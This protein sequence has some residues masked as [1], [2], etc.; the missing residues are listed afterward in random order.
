MSLDNVFSIFIGIMVGLTIGIFIGHYSVKDE[1]GKEICSEESSTH[2]FEKEQTIE[3]NSIGKEIL[4][5]EILKMNIQ[6]PQIVLAQAILESG[7]FES[8]VFQKFN[9]MFGMKIPRQRS[10]TC[11][12]REESGYAEY[13]DWQSS[14]VDYAIWQSCFARNLSE[15]EYFNFLKRVYAEDENYVVKIKRLIKDVDKR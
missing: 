9:N 3:D 5:K 12:N 11:L 1:E 4:L 13:L 15:E 7:H 2:K 10:T 8:N 14:L 6:H